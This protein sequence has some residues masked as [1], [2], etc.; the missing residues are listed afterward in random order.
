MA[1]EWARVLLLDM[2]RGES[3][4]VRDRTE[5]EETRIIMIELPPLQQTEFGK[6]IREVSGTGSHF[7]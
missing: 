5:G 6:L 2:G 1:G 7:D 4:L 3:E